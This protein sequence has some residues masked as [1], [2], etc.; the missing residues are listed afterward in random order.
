[1]AFINK[2]IEFILL[3]VIGYAIILA[4]VI[5]GFALFVKIMMA[6]YGI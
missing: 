6:K 1:M 4:L 5:A 3:R 2:L